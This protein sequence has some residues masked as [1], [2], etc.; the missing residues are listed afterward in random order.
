MSS[1]QQQDGLTVKPLTGAGGNWWQNYLAAV[2]G[3]DR[4]QKADPSYQHA[5]ELPAQALAR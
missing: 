5:P 3:P 1:A 2:W 4:A